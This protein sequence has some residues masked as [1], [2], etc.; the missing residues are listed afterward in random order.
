MNQPEGE[1]P[2]VDAKVLLV[3]DNEINQEIA[4]ELLTQFGATVD[5][6]SNGAEG[7]AMLGSSR[8]DVVFMDVQMPVMDGL[9]ATRR[10][11][12]TMS[13]SKDDL[14]IVAM[15]AHAMKGDYEKSVD[16]GMNDHITK[17]ID[18]NELYRTL[19]KWAAKKAPDKA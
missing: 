12:H 5:V 17:P 13:Y 15:T 3:E 14:P 9:E 4:V 6:A 7:I 11:R 1:M 8:Y 2:K 18:P 10:I 16:A 19:R